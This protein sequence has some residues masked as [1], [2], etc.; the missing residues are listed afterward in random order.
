VSIADR[1]AKEKQARIAA[2]K[3]SAWKIFLRDG[4]Q[5]AKIAE[6]AKD[7]SLGLA[8]LYYYFKDKRQIVYA[9]MLD[10]KNDTHGAFVSAVERGVTYGEL[11]RAYIDSFLGGIEHFQFFVLA[12][13]YYNYHHEYDLNDPIIREYDR[14]TREQ[15]DY[16]RSCFSG[17]LAEDRSD[18]LRVVISMILGFLRRYVLLPRK[19]WPHDQAETDRMISDLYYVVDLMLTD[20]GINLEANVVVPTV[21]SDVSARLKK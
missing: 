2:I 15:G 10:Y 9:L 17:G 8:T 4:F 18:R 20:L 21:R 14:V 19:S 11:A 16:V 5:N 13:S 6:I 12:D 1:R 7:C 3:K